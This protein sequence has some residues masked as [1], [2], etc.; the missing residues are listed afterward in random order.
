MIV[1]R[2]L[3]EDRAA[4][5]AVHTAAFARS[6]GS[7]VAEAALVDGLRADGDAIPA[8]AWGRP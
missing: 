6:G 3:S 2:E 1:R 4:I 8:R 5:F 7:D